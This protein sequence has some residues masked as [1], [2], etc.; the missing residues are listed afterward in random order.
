MYRPIADITVESNSTG[1]ETAEQR[2]APAP[3][4][5]HADAAS[6]R[7]SA[8][9]AAKWYG[10]AFIL[11]AS[12][13]WLR[14]LTDPLLGDASRFLPF[15]LIVAIC[16]YGGGIGPGVTS[17]ASSSVVASLLFIDHPLSPTKAD[18]FNLSLFV[19][20]AGGIAFLT[21]A[22][23]RARDR[24]NESVTRAEAVV[25]QRDQFV[26]RV[27]HEWRAPLNVLAGWTSQLQDRPHDPEFVARAAANM[28]RAI[29]T[30]KRLVGDLLDYSRGSRGR[31]S[32]HPVRMLI[33]TPI[34]ASL[35]TVRQ[36][37]GAKHI[38]LTLALADPGLR[39]WG[40]NQRLQQVFTNLLTNAIKFTPNG[41]RIVV[42]GQRT[43][44]LVELVVEDNGAGI[45]PQMLQEVF[46]PFAQ[47]HPARDTALGG[48]GLG[49]SIT[50]EIV[51]LHAGTIEASSAGPGRG[52]TFTV[53]LP[54]SAAVTDRSAGRE[55]PGGLHR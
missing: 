49:L 4:P 39:V 5:R 27:S 16:T 41:G 20:E 44:D 7:A 48:L 51:L 24:A 15:I 17:L 9:S 50:R 14:W 1:T 12:T 21:A 25:R 26:T 22:L 54:V 53:R 47:G 43:G 36:E 13:A 40:D 3:T 35:D 33:A 31:L 37:A 23:R 8:P 45:D 30:Q 19:I 18:L 28:L 29:E 2:A 38:E 32:I 6:A 10:L 42:R 11:V 55:A 46:E 52:S 34:E